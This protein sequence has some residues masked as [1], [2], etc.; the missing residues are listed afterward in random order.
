MHGF[1][2]GQLGTVQLYQ[3]EYMYGTV[4]VRYSST[5]AQ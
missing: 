3:W 4:P 5:L 2:K 1:A